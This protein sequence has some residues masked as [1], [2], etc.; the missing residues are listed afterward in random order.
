MLTLTDLLHGGHDP[1][2][3]GHVIVLH[4]GCERH[5]RI[6]SRHTAHRSVKIADTDI[7]G[8]CRDFAAPL[9]ARERGFLSFMQSRTRELRTQG[10]SA[11]QAVTTLSAEIKAKYPNWDNPE[12]LEGDIRRFYAE[13]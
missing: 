4:H 7:G 1:L 9:I 11:D 12:F 13:K 10:K 5:G 2:H 8:L 3:R 6:G